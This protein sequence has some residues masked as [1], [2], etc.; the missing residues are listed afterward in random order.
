M[1]I[2]KIKSYILVA[3]LAAI[4]FSCEDDFLETSPTSAISSADALSSPE[5]MTLVLDGLHRLMYAQYQIIPGGTSTRAGEHYWV[6]LDDVLVGGLIHSSRGNGWMRSDLQWIAHTNPNFTTTY[7]LWFQ[8]YHLIA[9]TSAIINKAAADGLTVD[10]NLKNILGQSHAYRAWAYYRLIT[11]YAKGYLIGNPQSDPGVPLL[12]GTSSPY[13]SGPRATV[14][15]VYAQM[16]ADIDGAIAYLSDGAAPAANKSHL[17]LNTAYGIKARIAMSKGDWATAE[18]ASRKARDGYSLMSESLWKSGFNTVSLPEVIW[19]STVI[20]TETVYYRSYFY[21]ICPTFNGSQNRSNPKLFDERW[22][23]QIPDTDFRKDQ[24]LPLAPNTNSAASN[25]QG[26][27]YLAD[28]NYTNPTDFWNAWGNVI[29]TYGMTTRHNTHPMMHV[30]FLQANPGTIDPDDIILMR[31]SEMYLNEAE[32]LVMQ[33]KLDDAR[34]LL[35]EFGITRDSAYDASVYVTKDD[36]MD[37]IKFQ[38]Y[39][40]LYGEGFGWT[41]HLRWDQA[42][43]LTGS[44][45]SSVLYQDGFQQ[46]KPSV[47]DDWI[48]KIPQAEIDA[49]PYINEADQN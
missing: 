36:L 28:P 42:I 46:A 14:A 47:N 7:Q 19:G 2:N 1:L 48:W 32:A 40:E 11:H 31:S 25:A 4:T 30:K 23:A 29:T 33:N 22:Y 10:A 34:D 9:E 20:D 44:G 37:H 49:N 21:L 41:D 3:L 43:D 26:G 45:A 6:P 16:E 5:N 12:T 8:R 13:E 27:S 39:V 17:S 15:E 18:D 38:R 35:D 24:A